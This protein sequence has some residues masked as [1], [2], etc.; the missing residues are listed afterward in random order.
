M[1]EAIIR[2]GL[3]VLRLQGKDARDLLQRLSTNDVLSRKTGDVV[4]NVISNEKGRIIDVVTMIFRDDALWLV[5]RGP[6]TT[7]GEHVDKMTFREDVQVA[8]APW[9]VAHVIGGD[10]EIGAPARGFVVRGEVAGV[11]GVHVIG[12]RAVVEQAI[13]A[14]PKL[15]DF[16]AYRVREGIAAYG[17]EITADHNPHEARLGKLIDWKKGCYVGQEVVARLDTYKKVQRYLVRLRAQNALTR[18][19]PVELGGEVV[20]DVTSAAGDAALA[21]V[22]SSAA[23]ATAFTVGGVDARVVPWPA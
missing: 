22:K 20:G 7:A 1:V 5:T 10:M 18:G 4:D 12:P 6:A 9:V 16:E 23:E 2:E 11:P 14:L 19:A 17:H 21:Y 15:A 3:G 13:S 8:A